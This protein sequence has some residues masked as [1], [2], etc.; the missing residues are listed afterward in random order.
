MTEK[1]SFEEQTRKEVSREL[2]LNS[3]G[4]SEEE[5]QSILLE[6]KPDM[7]P[8]KKPEANKNS[9]TMDWFDILQC[10]GTALVV[11]LL[12]FVFLVRVIGVSGTSMYST[13]HHDDRL[14]VSKLFYTPEQGDIIIL[15]TDAYEEPLVKR[16]IAVGGQTV[17]IDFFTGEVFVDGEVLD[18]PY[19]YETTHNDE[20]FKGPV[21]VPDGCLF[22]MGDNRNNSNDSRLSRIGF[23]D[24]RAVI[25]KVLLV[26]TPAREQDG[27]RDWH[28]AGSVY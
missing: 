7:P 26:L 16:I 12:I 27:K 14:L 23:I 13:L 22:V 8:D 17:D 4:I 15:R 18:E 9:E 25:G 1:Q 19:I 24:K 3:I 21:T 11:A 28:R 5:K 2:L 20:G 10:V 6:Q